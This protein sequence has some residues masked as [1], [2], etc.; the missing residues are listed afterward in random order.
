MQEEALRQHKTRSKSKKSMSKKQHEQREV[1][2]MTLMSKERQQITHGRQQTTNNN[3]QETTNNKQLIAN[4]TT[5][6]N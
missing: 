1:V 2:A 3:K 4:K 6:N 5:H